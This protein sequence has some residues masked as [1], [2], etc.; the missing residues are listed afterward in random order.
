MAM[1]QCKE[2]Q[3][4]VSKTASKCPH[5]GVTNPGVTPGEHLVGV[6]IMFAVFGFIWWQM[7]EDTKPVSKVTDSSNYS[8]SKPSPVIEKN[9]NVS[10]EDLTVNKSIKNAWCVKGKIRNQESKALK[11]YVK[12]KFLDSKGD[13][14]KSAMAPVNGNDS[15]NPGQAG[16]FEYFTS[17]NDF[18]NVTHY[19]VIFVGS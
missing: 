19:D 18:K 16:V 1:T 3:K 8:Y 11:G 13:V 5:C 15:L 10:V 9:A 17:P 7:K 14:L 4:D 2:C 6:L 12:I